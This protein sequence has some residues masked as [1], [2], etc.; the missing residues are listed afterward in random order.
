MKKASLLLL[1]LFVLGALTVFWILSQ[2]VPN[3][4]AELLPKTTVALIELPDIP[5]ALQHWHGSALEKISDSSQMKTVLEI[6]E[7]T[8]EEWSGFSVNPESS[9]SMKE[10]LSSLKPGRF[11]AALVPEEKEGKWI[12]GCQ[13]FGS[14]ASMEKVEAQIVT[15]FDEIEGIGIP[16]TLDPEKHQGELIKQRNYEGFSLVMAFHDNWFFVSSDLAVLEHTLDFSAKRHTSSDSLSASELYQ[17]T[18][19]PLFSQKDLCFYIAKDPLLEKFSDLSS[20]IKEMPFCEKAQAL[21]SSLCCREH[22]VEEKLF[23]TGAFKTPMTLSHEGIHLTDPTT[24]IYLEK[25]N[26]WEKML[27]QLK[28]NSL[29]PAMIAQWLSMANIDF[30]SLGELLKPEISFLSSWKKEESLPKA[31]FSMPERNPAAAGEWINKTAS[32]LGTTVVTTQIKGKTDPALI[33]PLLAGSGSFNPVFASFGDSFL[34][35]T[36][37]NFVKTLT[38]RDAT[39]PTLQA[40]PGFDPVLYQQANEFFFYG[41][42]PEIVEQLWHFAKP[43]LATLLTGENKENDFSLETL[44][45]YLSPLIVAGS[46]TETGLLLQVRG[47][48][49][50]TPLYLMARLLIALYFSEQQNE[51]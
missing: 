50:G 7:E 28:E 11:F 42:I 12:A 34:A 24:L 33:M 35:A 32:Q 10:L 20:L 16:Q 27:S 47:P 38:E 15:L 8:L 3:K 25:T 21:G 49:G 36:D 46:H 5:T 43:Q 1:S 23:L 9:Q 26:D 17:Q 31:L 41:A 48:C 18:T 4:A 30:S 40:A 37:E 39:A 6:A 2:Q 13:F 51:E 44:L 19:A 22:D 45:P 14:K 29:F